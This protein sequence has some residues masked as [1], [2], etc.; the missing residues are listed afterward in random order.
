MKRSMVSLALLIA[1]LIYA[2]SLANGPQNR[3]RADSHPVEQLIRL[4]EY[5]MSLFDSHDVMLD[6]GDIPAALKQVR[7]HPDFSSLHV[8]MALRRHHQGVYASIEAGTKARI[9][10][11]CL[12]QTECADDWSYMSG[13]LGLTILPR[14]HLA[15]PYAVDYAAARALLELPAKVTIPQ[16]IE[17]LQNEE[18]IVWSGSAEATRSRLER[19]RRC[20]LAYR[21]ICILIGVKPEYTRSVKQR[22]Q[23]IASLMRQLGVS[24]KRPF[25]N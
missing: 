5:T 10:I 14:G 4:S 20:D 11:S 12:N 6:A 8:L 1:V 7:T 22:D 24:P 9:L 16:L 13:E 2:Y 25:P 18:E 23:A 21:Y 17:V 15:Q 3:P 19:L